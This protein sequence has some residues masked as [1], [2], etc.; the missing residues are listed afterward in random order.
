M[1]FLRSIYDYIFNDQKTQEEQKV[2]YIQEEI[3][4]KTIV[5]GNSGTKLY[6]IKVLEKL[7]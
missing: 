7:H 6:F 2:K 3:I 1:N 5:L 4:L